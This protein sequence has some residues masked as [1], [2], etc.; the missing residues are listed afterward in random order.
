MT[1]YQRLHIQGWDAS[2]DGC[3]ETVGAQVEFGLARRPKSTPR[4]KA[5]EVEL[6]NG[7]LARVGGSG[8]VSC[9]PPHHRPLTIGVTSSM[10]CGREWLGWR[11]GGKGRSI[12]P[13][14]TS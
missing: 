1:A 11:E 9:P 4:T 10:L 5:A 13:E 12:L 3:P 2:R 6:G 8:V 7:P 14:F